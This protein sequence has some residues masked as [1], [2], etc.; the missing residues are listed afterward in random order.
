MRILFRDSTGSLSASL[1]SAI[2][3]A[4]RAAFSQVPK[5]VIKSLGNQKESNWLLS[6]SVLGIKKMQ[7]INSQF[8]NKNSPTDVLSFP[9]GQQFFSAP[10]NDLG[11]ILICLPLAK[12]Q[13]AEYEGTLKEELERLTVHGLLHLCGYDHEINEKEARK[14]F[15][16]QEKIL[17]SLSNRFNNRKPSRLC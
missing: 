14:M 9:R 5:K 4:A 15:R 16:L 2:K 3:K 12:K 6:I 7:G 8:R 10:S 17:K 11:D 13:A 1:Q